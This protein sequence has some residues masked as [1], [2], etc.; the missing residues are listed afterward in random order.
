[1]T[2]Q[3]LIKAFCDNHQDLI[4]YV[5]SLPDEEFL[6]SN[7]GKWTAGQ[8][9]IH[10][11]LT[12]LPLGKALQS[13][14]FILRKFGKVNRA[15][16]DYNTIIGNYL[17]TNLQAPQQF[18]PEQVSVEQRATITSDINKVLLKIQESLSHYTEEELDTLVLPHPLLGNLTVREMLYL[19]TYHATHHHKQTE[20]NLKQK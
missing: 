12:L 5:N 18:L 11:Y 1:M 16:L 7:K 20:N 9:L 13:K 17:K 2:K 6:Y 15:P 3:E 4:D 14:E 19:T 8:Q 10:V